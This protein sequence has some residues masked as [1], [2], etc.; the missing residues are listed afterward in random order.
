MSVLTRP[1]A[2]LATAAV[3]VGLIAAPGAAYAADTTTSLSA[4]EMAAALDEVAAAS[5]AAAGDGWKAALTFS[6]SPTGSAGNETVVYDK[7]RGLY[8]DSF[9]LQGYPAVQ[10]FVADGRGSYAQAGS[11]RER[12]A[13]KM[14]GRSA[15]KYVF[16]ADKSLDLAEFVAESSPDP[17]TLAGTD[18]QVGGSRTTHDDGSAEYTIVEDMDEGSAELT[19]RV[20][21]AGVLTGLRATTADSQ[22]DSAET[23]LTYTYGPQTVT[24]PASSATI[25]ANSLAG[26]MAYLDMATLVQRAAVTGAADAR[27]AA[28]GGKVKVTSLR[29]VV[30]RDVA[31]V[32]RTV[33]VSMVKV[34]NVTG[35][36]RVYA[37]NP[38]TEKTVAYTVK[39]SGKKVVVKKV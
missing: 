13:L 16:T 36:V 1:A 4:A 2:L 35:G 27:K 3:T 34:K 22:G 24:L 19:F 33:K 9:T 6:F 39:A 21:A 7:V 5:A 37:T 23:A 30:S 11:T 8:S 28:K 20:S 31:A 14:M 32:N 38:W 25:P 18:Y 10:V 17:V 12:A 29:K 26:A 15:V